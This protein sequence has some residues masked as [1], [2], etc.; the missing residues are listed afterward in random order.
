MNIPWEDV[1]IFL[2]LAQSRSMSGA[3][4]ALNVRQ[5]TISRR[6]AALEQMLGYALFQRSA[7][8]VSLTAA[9]ERLVGPATKMAEWAGELSR[10]AQNRSGRAAGLVRIAAPPGVA[11][12]FV[13]PFAAWLR[14]KEPNIT[15]QVLTGIHYVDLVRGEADLALR[16]R[17]PSQPELVTV[18]SLTHRNAVF[19][20]KDYAQKLPSR[21]GLSDLDWICW[22]PP[23]EDLPPNP[24]LHAWIPDFRP[25]FST[26]NFLIM[27]RAAESGLGAI[28]LGSVRHRFTDTSTLVPLKLD[29]REHQ[30]SSLH[31]VCAKSALDVPR[32]RLVAQR[33]GDELARTREI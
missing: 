6:I 17:A 12:D 24:Q 4:K 19:V 13:A 15:L 18:A 5:P 21:C 25:A 3:A 28:V 31:L 26:D 29:L 14:S 20:S 7:S 30:K 1:Q 2:T 10:S 32:I 27:R 16:T 33:L 23:Y 8:G 11:S 9:G 22:A